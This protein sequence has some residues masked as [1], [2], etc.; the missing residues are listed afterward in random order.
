[1]ASILEPAPTPAEQLVTTEPVRARA[2]RTR[3]AVALV[4][5]VL[6]LVVAAGAFMLAAG[7][8]PVSRLAGWMPMGTV[9]YAELRLDPPGDQGTKVADLLGHFPGF[10]DRSQLDAK[11]TELAD[12]L[13]GKATGGAVTYSSMKPWIGDAV[14]VGLTRPPSGPA[15]APADAPGLAAVA[16]KDAPALRDWLASHV[17]PGGTTESSGGAQITIGT[18][19]GVAWAYTVVDDVMLAG[20]KSAVEAAIGTHGASGFAASEP[21]RSAVS[22]LDGSS[23]GFGFL[24]TKAL[25]TAA[26]AAR[27]ATTSAA[28]AAMTAAIVD[29]VAPWTAFA[30]RAQSDAIEIDATTPKTSTAPLSSA[31]G[32]SPLPT[33]PPPVNTTSSLA[34]HLPADTILAVESRDVGPTLVAA[35]A[36]ASAFRS[37]EAS[38]GTLGGRSSPA[39]GMLG[40]LEGS[41]SFLGWMGD[42]AFVI[43][44]DAGTPSAG[45]V[46]VATDPAAAS[47]ALGQLKALISFAGPSSGITFRD[48][49]YGD[50]TITIA[51][52][53][54]GATLE[55]LLSKALPG[56]S[57]E[58]GGASAPARLLPIP[59]G[60]V[61]IAWTVQRGLLVAGA[62]D[63]FVKAILDTRA[64]SSLAT[65]PDYRTALDRA[66]ASNAGQSFLDIPALTSLV[67][68]SL[69]PAQRASYER[70]IKPFIDPLG[71]VASATLAGDPLRVRFVV[72][73]K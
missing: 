62:G 15:D 44:D 14:A 28:S 4:V 51:D 21:F 35:L 38:G 10:A 58:S 70:D 40:L 54:D 26:L 19:N 41:D 59:S 61:E 2:S 18:R 60:H 69:T 67:A 63:A 20:E 29:R 37:A 7:S 13:V 45:V 3:W 27:P 55:R 24:D 6:A 49:P 48:E 9:A 33:F 8:A 39:A 42:G 68:P 31:T 34:A 36:Q 72:T 23:L 30:L 71:G 32:G 16:T 56:R 50:G 1:M 12:R 53:G 17:P 64:E 46:A 5:A 73:V 25:I 11:L 43:R 22:S 65:T 52:L 57:G 47:T 66:G